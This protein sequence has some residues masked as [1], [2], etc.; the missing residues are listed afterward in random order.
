MFLKPP[1]PSCDGGNPP[2]GRAQDSEINEAKKVLA[3]EMT[4]LIHGEEEA[5]K[6]AGAAEALFGGQGSMENVPTFMVTAALL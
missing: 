3:F 6:A 5:S 4:K 1:H 2:P